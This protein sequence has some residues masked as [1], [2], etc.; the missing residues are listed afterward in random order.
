MFTSFADPAVLTASRGPFSKRSVSFG[1]GSEKVR[2]LNIGGWLVLEPWI[3]PSIFTSVD[4]SL[5][6]VDE[7]TL[8]QKLG[9][10]AAYNILKPH[11]GIAFPYL[12]GGAGPNYCLTASVLPPPKPFCPYNFKHG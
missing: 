10:A 11:V 2:G 4:Q 6:I 7:F 3:T 1:F 9:S 12:Y 8:T 5:G